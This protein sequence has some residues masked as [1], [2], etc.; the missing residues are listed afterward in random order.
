[1]RFLKDE[2]EQRGATVIYA[3]HIFDGLEFWPSHVAYVA[4]GKMQMLKEAADVPELAQG[5]LLEMVYDLLSKE[6]D[7][8]LKARGPRPVEWDPSREG[9]VDTFSYVFNN[10]WVPGTLGT[11]L[12]TNAVMRM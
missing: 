3:T 1:M 12:S 10:G 11:S 6:A 8:V 9:Q 7:A 4:R 2:C 5:R